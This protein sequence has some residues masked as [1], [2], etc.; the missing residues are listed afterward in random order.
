MARSR[1]RSAVK[2]G[3]RKTESDIVCWFFISCT[4]L[5]LA[6]LVPMWS[7]ELSVSLGFY[8]AACALTA[9]TILAR[10]LHCVHYA[11]GF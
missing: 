10:P 8:Q 11:P 9:G 3:T 5:T 4:F 6:G 7:H 1:A 2:V